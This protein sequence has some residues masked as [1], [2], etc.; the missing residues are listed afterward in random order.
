MNMYAVT[1]KSNHRHG[2]YN[3]IEAIRSCIHFVEQNSGTVG[4]HLIELQPK[5]IHNM[6]VHIPV[7]AENLPYKKIHEY[8]KTLDVNTDI[9]QLKSKSDMHNWSYYCRKYNNGDLAYDYAESSGKDN[10][11]RMVGNTKKQFWADYEQWQKETEKP[12]FQE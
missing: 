4:P 5:G 1:F 11:Q 9:K 7:T 6:H 8:A 12:I 2:F 3:D 10:K